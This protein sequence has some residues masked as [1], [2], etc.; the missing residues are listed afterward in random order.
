MET[1]TF[2]WFNLKNS[3]TKN[4]FS[5][6]FDELANQKLFSGLAEKFCKIGLKSHNYCSSHESVSLVPALHINEHDYSPG[7]FVVR[8]SP[9]RALN[10]FGS[11]AKA[12]VRKY[13]F[14]KKKKQKSQSGSYRDHPKSRKFDLESRTLKFQFPKSKILIPISK[15]H[16]PSRI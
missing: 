14:L 9:D 15:Y 1:K 4:F 16:I 10:E 2:L 12:T 7:D 11:I 6:W 5:V 8:S 3:K 13:F